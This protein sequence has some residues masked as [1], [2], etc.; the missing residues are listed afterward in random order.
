[1]KI[2]RVKIPPQIK[3][4]LIPKNGILGQKKQPS[5]LYMI[6]TISRLHVILISDGV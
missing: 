4:F 2:L 6:W 5:M 3:F 1:M